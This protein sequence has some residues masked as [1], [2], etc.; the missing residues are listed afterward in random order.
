MIAYL[1]AML[2]LGCIYALMALGLN[3]HYGYTGLVNFGHVAFFAIGAYTSALVTTALGLPIPMG[4]ALALLAAGIAAYPLG[5]VSLRLR[6]DYLAIVTL[7]FS[8]VIRAIL[9]NEAWLTRGTHGISNIPRPFSQLP[10][11]ANEL[12]YLGLVSGLLVII[13]LAIE[14]LGRAPFGRTLRAIRE[15]EEAAVS[16]GKTI[17]NFKMRSF[18]IGAAI[19]GLAGAAYAHYINYVV[20]DQFIPLVTFYIWVAMILGG[21]GSN[22]GVVLGTLL[23]LVFLEGTRFVKDFVPLFTDVQL[24]ALRFMVVGVALIL[25]MLY[26]PQGIWGRKEI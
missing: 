14:R 22:K 13:Y 9:V 1:S 24:A 25:L 2:I 12:A 15:N 4:F 8:E 20:P 16:L 3:L 18:M 10:T 5:L 21:A 6:T 23:L 7:G 17:A 26:R 11:G 19:A